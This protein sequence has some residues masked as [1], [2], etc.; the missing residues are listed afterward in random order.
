M[1]EG[2]SLIFDCQP[3]LGQS[4]QSIKGGVFDSSGGRVVAY[5]AFTDSGACWNDQ[6][7]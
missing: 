5:L 2:P 4:I 7:K 1:Q 3:L 6:K